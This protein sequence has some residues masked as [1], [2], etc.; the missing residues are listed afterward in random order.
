MAPHLRGLEEHRWK[1]HH[2]QRRGSGTNFKKDYEIK[3]DGSLVLGQDQD[4]PG[5]GF[6]SSQSFKGSLTNVNV[7]SV[8]LKVDKITRLSECC[9]AGQGDVYSWSD[10]VHGIK[11]NTRVVIPS[12]CSKP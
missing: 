2:L 6:Q 7:W 4:T 8:Y 3:A 9:K 1:I 5:G 11:G 10:F 12:S